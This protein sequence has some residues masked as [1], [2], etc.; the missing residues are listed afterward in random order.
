MA[1]SGCVSRMGIRV[2]RGYVYAGLYL[3]SVQAMCICTN[4]SFS[5]KCVS[6][7]TSLTI[8][9]SGCVSVG[10]LCVYDCTCIQLCMSISC[11]LGSI[12]ARVLCCWSVHLCLCVHM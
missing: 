9:V 4:Q 8:G 6:I 7:Y 5:G 2:L 3:Q 1:P 10:S 11:V 12:S